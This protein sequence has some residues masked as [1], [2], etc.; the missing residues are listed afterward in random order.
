MNQSDDYLA[1][2]IKEVLRL[3]EDHPEEWDANTAEEILYGPY[4]VLLKDSASFYEKHW[5]TLRRLGLELNDPDAV[6]KG[7]PVLSGN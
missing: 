2:Q 3:Q 1:T 7:L 4:C 5:R 6:E